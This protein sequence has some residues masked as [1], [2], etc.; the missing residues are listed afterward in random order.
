[1]TAGVYYFLLYRIIGYKLWASLHIKTSGHVS[2]ACSGA[3]LLCGAALPS[4]PGSLQQL[5]AA[6][7]GYKRGIDARDSGSQSAAALASGP[8]EF[9]AS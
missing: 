5:L 7:P 3:Y 8:R 2:C 4:P 9:A 1:M 6:Q